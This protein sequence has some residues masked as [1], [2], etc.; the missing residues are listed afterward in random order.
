MF[1]GKAVLTATIQEK[2]YKRQFA[3]LFPVSLADLFAKEFS[4]QDITLT[5]D[6]KAVVAAF[7]A[8]FPAPEQKEPLK[9]TSVKDGDSVLTQH[10]IGDVIAYNVH[11]ALRPAFHA[12]N[13]KFDVEQRSTARAELEKELGVAKPKKTIKIDDAVQ[14]LAA[15]LFEFKVAETLELAIVEAKKR[16]KVA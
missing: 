9:A 16:L 15:T 14:Q 13:A 8:A 5:D 11:P 10:E 2:E 4:G 6:Q 7:D 3:K 12:V 1:N